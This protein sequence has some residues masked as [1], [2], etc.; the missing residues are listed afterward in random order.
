MV[1]KKM[2]WQDCLLLVLKNIVSGNIHVD[3]NSDDAVTLSSVCGINN[4]LSTNQKITRDANDNSVIGL[5]IS[6]INDSGSGTE[7]IEDKDS[8]EISQCSQGGLDNLNSDDDD[9]DYSVGSNK[10]DIP[11]ELSLINLKN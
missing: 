9:D 7:D 6:G 8:R 1:I 3:K 11:P 2:L 10:S 5:S 4:I